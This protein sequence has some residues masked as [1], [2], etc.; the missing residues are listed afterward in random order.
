METLWPSA[1]A[2]ASQ[3]LCGAKL[4]LFGCKMLA[5]RP[6]E[7]RLGQLAGRAL[8]G[9]FLHYSPRVQGAMRVDILGDGGEVRGK[10]A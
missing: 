1:M 8:P 3:R 6:P 2:L 7:R 9:V 5:R 10:A 4:P